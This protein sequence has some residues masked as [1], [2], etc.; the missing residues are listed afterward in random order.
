MVSAGSSAKAIRVEFQLLRAT[1][2]DP[3]VLVAVGFVF[4]IGTVV[5]AIAQMVVVHT[6]ARI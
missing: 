4:T 3:R 5:N 6:Q 2:A 1:F